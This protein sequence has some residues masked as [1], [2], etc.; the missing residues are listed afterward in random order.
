MRLEA[1]DDNVI[2]RPIIASGISAGGVVLPG[3]KQFEDGCVVTSVGPNVERL[4]PGDI[5]VR[6]DPPR[7]TITDDDT[8]EILLIAAD[9]DILARILPEEC[10]ATETYKEDQA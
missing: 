2:L 1:L 9:V 5:V 10:G 4:V 3:A 7:Y 8:G 6:P